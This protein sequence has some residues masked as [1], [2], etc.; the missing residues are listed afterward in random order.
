MMRLVA[1][2][3]SAVLFAASL[4]PGQTPAPSAAAPDAKPLHLHVVGASV[5]GGFRDGPLTGAQRVH[6]TVTLPALLQPWLAEH[7][8]VGM[9]NSAK[10][11]MM[12]TNPQKLGA[13]QLATAQKKAPDV[14][15]AVDF[16]FWFAYGH[17]QGDEATARRE[18]LAQGLE[19]LA[20][21]TVPVLV[22][23]LPDMQGAA[24]RML[25]PR[26]IPGPALLAELNAQI[27]AFA[28]ERP[29]W[30]VVPLAAAVRAM[31][32]D[33]VRLPLA[34]GA[35]PTPPGALLQEDRLHATRLGMA[36]LGHVLQPFL[37]AAVPSGH[38]LAKRPWT[39]EQWIAAA[40]A[41]DELASLP[42]VAPAA[43][44]AETGK[45]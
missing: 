4:L 37:A 3:L 36:Y 41:E 1:S 40:G 24:A 27:A 14:L 28:K 11:L 7:G 31:K 15:L 20:P 16:L 22:G 32:Q 13:E 30:R 34:A 2:I 17:V 10:L 42:A 19:L 45:H 44:P 5:S 8:D 21:F 6:E 26:Q 35:L 33:G 29:N 39:F 25:S 12:F 23:D 18:R 9:A 43:V 38:P